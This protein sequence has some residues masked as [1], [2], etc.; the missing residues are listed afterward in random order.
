MVDG[1]VA[2]TVFTAMSIP[3]GVAPLDTK[4]TVPATS[5]SP[6]V[7]DSAQTLLTTPVL[8]FTVSEHDCVPDWV[9]LV[10]TAVPATALAIDVAILKLTPG[11]V[12]G[13]V[14]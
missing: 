7:S 8:E 5:Q 13:S 6:A 4:S 10:F 9:P 1:S 2:D 14:Q 11:S 3:V 12:P